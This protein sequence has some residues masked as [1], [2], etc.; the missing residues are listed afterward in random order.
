MVFNIPESK[1]WLCLTP[2]LFPSQSP[3][4]TL[5][6]G[7]AILFHVHQRQWC[8]PQ[9]LTWTTLSPIPAFSFFPWMD[10]QLPLPCCTP[11]ME[12][13]QQKQTPENPELL[14]HRG[15]LAVNVCVCVRAHRGSSQGVGGEIMEYFDTVKKKKKKETKDGL[16]RFSKPAEEAGS[17]QLF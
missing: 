2:A 6:T 10:T 1:S 3:P 15:A 5:T 4:P 14:M 8:Y 17:R 13:P 16:A 12:K 11:L 7:A 9:G